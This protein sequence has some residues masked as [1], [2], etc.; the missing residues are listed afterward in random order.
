MSRT[1]STKNG[2]VESLKLLLRCGCKPEKRRAGSIPSDDFGKRSGSHARGAMG[3]RRRISLLI[4]P[5][6]AG[7][8]PTAR[9]CV[10]STASLS[11]NGSTASRATCTWSFRRVLLLITSICETPTMPLQR[12]ATGWTAAPSGG[13]R[14][15]LDSGQPGLRSETEAA[16]ARETTL[17]M[18]FFVATARAETW[19]LMVADEK[20]MSEPEI[21]D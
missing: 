15:G 7:T 20:V 1:F 5:T 12:V 16:T 10:K 13:R 3:F 18:L 2:S 8:P 21:R 9:W 17:L 11:T 14:A 19:Y 4:E 6:I